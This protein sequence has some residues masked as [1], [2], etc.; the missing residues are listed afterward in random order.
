MVGGDNGWIR[1][2]DG[3]EPLAVVVDQGD[4]TGRRADRL[5]GDSDDLV[6]GFFGFGDVSQGRHK[7]IE[8]VALVHGGGLLRI[9]EAA[10]ARRRALLREYAS[11]GPK[12]VVVS[13]QSLE[14]QPTWSRRSDPIR[15]TESSAGSSANGLLLTTNTD[16]NA[17]AAPASI[18]FTDLRLAL[19]DRHTP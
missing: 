7:K 4:A 9:S 12:D 19:L 16:E 3:L 1:G 2:A 18:G 17:I 8:R 13:V 15:Q 5:D 6:D 11:F 10:S 14:A